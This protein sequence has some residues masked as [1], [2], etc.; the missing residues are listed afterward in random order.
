MSVPKAKPQQTHRP[1]ED[2]QGSRSE[3]RPKRGDFMSMT[4]GLVE[5]STLK[6]TFEYVSRD[7]HRIRG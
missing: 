1:G 7:N 2:W 6:N 4:W 3:R 5:Y